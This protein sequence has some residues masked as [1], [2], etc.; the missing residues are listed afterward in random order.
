MHAGS[1]LGTDIRIPRHIA[2]YE[3]APMNSFESTIADS[4][5]GDITAVYRAADEWALSFGNV[6]CLEELRDLRY[7]TVEVVLENAL[8]NTSAFNLNLELRELFE[9]SGCTLL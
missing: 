4:W 7:A 2:G 6:L 3:P 9:A 1:S 5:R 8:R